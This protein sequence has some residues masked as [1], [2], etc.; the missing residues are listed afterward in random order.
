MASAGGGLGVP[1]AKDLSVAPLHH[2]FVIRDLRSRLC[3]CRSWAGGGGGNRTREFNNPTTPL[4]PSLCIFGGG[5]PFV[6]YTPWCFPAFANVHLVLPDF[7]CFPSS[8]YKIPPLPGS[9]FQMLFLPCSS[10]WSPSQMR[11]LPFLNPIVVYV[12]LM[13]SYSPGFCLVFWAGMPTVKWWA[14][15]IFESLPQG[16]VRSLEPSRHLINIIQIEIDFLYN[17]YFQQLQDSCLLKE[18]WDRNQSNI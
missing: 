14:L 5:L 17:W 13:T 10:S 7:S 15:I 9:P 12:F 3:L 4:F 16:A 11:F 8:L 1:V 6:P 2:S 18:I